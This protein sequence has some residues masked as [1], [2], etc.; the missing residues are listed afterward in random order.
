MNVICNLLEKPAQDTEEQCCYVV[1][2]DQYKV[3]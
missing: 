3:N 2:C 1:H